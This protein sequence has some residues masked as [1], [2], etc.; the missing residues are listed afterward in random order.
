MKLTDAD[1][2]HTADDIPQKDVDKF[3]DIE[4]QANGT[5][6]NGEVAAV[7]DGGENPAFVADSTRL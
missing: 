1:I 6:Q 5:A 2:R 7:K 4:L 3:F